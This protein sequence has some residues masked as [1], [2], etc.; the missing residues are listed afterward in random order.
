MIE[1]THTVPTRGRS[2][3]A[4]LILENIGELIG[5]RGGTRTLSGVRYVGES[6]ETPRDFSGS[7]KCVEIIIFESPHTFAHTVSAVIPPDLNLCDDPQEYGRYEDG[8][9][10]IRIELD[11]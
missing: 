5:A 6:S 1:S 2:R 4:N 8:E 7:A 3:K 9:R 11:A 10:L